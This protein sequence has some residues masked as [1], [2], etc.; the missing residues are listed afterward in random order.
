MIGE[1]ISHYKIVEKIGGGG[2]GV[3]YRALDAKLGRPVALKFLPA[4]MAADPGALERFQREARAASALNHPNICTIYEI[5]EFHGQHFIAMEF[6]EGHTLKH[7]I[8]KGPMPLDDLLD[9]GIQVSNALDAAHSR[10]IIHR[11]IKPAN[12]FCVRGGAVKVLDFG[13]AKILSPR[14]TASGITATGLPTAS[15]EE[16][17]S[18][19]GTAMGTVMYMSPEQAMGEELDARTDLFSFGAVL[20]EMSTGALPSRGTTSAAIFDAILH[21]MPV[22]PTRLNPELPAEFERIVHKALEKDRKLRY[23]HASDLR[24]DF[25]RL[26]RDSDSGRAHVEGSAP[27]AERATRRSAADDAADDAA[28]ASSNPVHDSAATPA[29]DVRSARDIPSPPSAASDRAFAAAAR[30]SATRLS[31]SSSS[32][33]V[34]AAK[35]HKGKLLAVAVL[36]L[37]LLAAAAYGIFALVRSR[38]IFPFQNFTITQLTTNGKSTLAAISPDGKYLLSVVGDKGKSS[39]WLRHI[40]TNSDTQIV[41]PAGEEYGNLAFSPDGGYIY[42]AK[43][44]MNGESDL[45]RV[46]VLGGAPQMLAKD[47]D[48]APAFSPDGIHLAYVRGN[49]PEAG[50][51]HI[52][53]ANLDGTEEKSIVNGLYRDVPVALAWA[54]DRAHIYGAVPGK[55]GDRSSIVSYD[56]ASGGARTVATTPELLI[57]MATVPDE[58]GFLVLYRNRATGSRNPQIGYVALSDGKLRA[59]THDTNFYSL[60]TLSADRSNLATV[61]RKNSVA[62]DVYSVAALEPRAASA[63]AA[64]NATPHG[65]LPQAHEGFPQSHEVF[66][67]ADDVLDFSWAG[68]SGFYLSHSNRLVRSSSDGRDEVQLAVD[69]HAEISQVYGCNGGAFA[70]FVWS[71]HGGTSGQNIWRA[72]AD[73]SNL[74]QISNGGKDAG[75]ACS[76]DGQWVYYITA[77]DPQILSTSQLRRQPASGGASETSPGTAL[78]G[79]MILLDVANPWEIWPSPTVGLDASFDGKWL[80]YLAARHDATKLVEYKIAVAEWGNTDARSPRSLDADVRATGSPRL[81]PD[82]KAVVTSIRQAGRDSLWIQPLDGSPGR[83]LVGPVEG[84]IRDYQFSPNGK[85]LAILEVQRPSDAVLL[86]DTAK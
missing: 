50:R 83:L 1:N 22:A 53:V 26:K 17:L 15:A 40:D 67:Q 47:V 39:L 4:D 71:D 18:S 68:N 13:L 59:I 2:M 85:S 56:V 58:G 23:Q 73:G 75:P 54:P 63:A 16:L 38:Q 24:A 79:Y 20:Y 3:V 45:Y 14:R 46:P 28:A 81:T 49:D 36:V 55:P 65:V 72:D 11:D 42:F 84:T 80:T 32:A 86:H 52:L 33:V 8:A 29:R 35:Q 44:A 69:P 37:A 70:V 9:T 41:P 21:R 78:P 43:T 31:G 60:L 48:T 51:F 25:E 76:P 77:Q 5:D 19:P 10:G 82:G 6:L 7:A 64:A 66:P 74:K 27:A 62:L 30:D 61:Q 57:S 34:E 12:I